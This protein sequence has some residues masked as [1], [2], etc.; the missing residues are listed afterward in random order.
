MEFTAKRN[1]REVQFQNVLIPIFNTS[2]K[3]S[4][5]VRGSIVFLATPKPVVNGY[6]ELSSDH[7]TSCS[8]L[9]VVAQLGSS[10]KNSVE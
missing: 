10:Q 2:L 3:Q 1:L 6:H 5:T 8:R 7:M 9:Y 4:T